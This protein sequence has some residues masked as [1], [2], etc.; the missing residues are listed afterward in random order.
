LLLAQNTFGQ[1]V[2]QHRLKA[3]AGLTL[4][5]PVFNLDISST[6]GGPDA[7]LHYGLSDQL[8]ITADAAFIGLPGKGRYPSTAIVPVRLGLKYF[9]LPKIY[10]G[11]KAGLGIYTILKASA[12][13]FAY[14]FSGGYMITRK[15]E[16]GVLYDGYT[17]KNS[18]FGYVGVR[19][20]YVF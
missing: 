16:A 20:G 9:P 10:A 17:N 4:A 11:A 8:S 2:P 14:S 5:F 15:I 3:G 18:S 19:A 1:T 13:H 12:N 6:G 7:I